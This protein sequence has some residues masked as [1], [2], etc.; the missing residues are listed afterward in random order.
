[1]PGTQFNVFNWTGLDWT[2]SIISMQWLWAAL[3]LGLILLSALWFARFDPSREGLRSLRRKPTEVKEDQPADE[4]KKAPR[5]A[6]PSLSPFVSK[7]AQVNPFLG[8]LFAELR[9][10]FNGRRWWW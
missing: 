1:M 2:L 10:L 9:L 7:L 8:V 5:I 6:L 3:G 4:Q